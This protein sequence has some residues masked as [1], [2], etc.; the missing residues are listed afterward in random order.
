MWDGLVENK[1]LTRRGLFVA[2]ILGVLV[3]AALLWFSIGVVHRVEVRSDNADYLEKVPSAP[4]YMDLQMKVSTVDMNTSQIEIGMVVLPKGALVDADGG[5]TRDVEFTVVTWGVKK[6]GTMYVGERGDTT[7]LSDRMNGT[8]SDYPWDAHSVNY[9]VAFSGKDAAGRRVAIP[10]RVRFSGS[11][12]G[13]DIA[14]RATGS[15]TVGGRDLNVVVTRSTVTQ[16]VVVFSIIL[17]WVLIVTVIA[18]VVHVSAFGHDLQTMMFAFFGTLLFAMTAFRNAMPGT[19]PMGVLSDY[20]AFFWGYLIAIVGI[21]I[22]TITWVRR[23]PR[24][25][26]KGPEKKT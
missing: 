17:I 24:G 26:K 14:A 10:S 15:K 12:Q 11:I 6:S 16:V 3:A 2:V 4:G 18:M 1:H 25:E 20:A 13:L 21:G 5:A 19:P 9:T 8:V 22:L 23:L 7:S